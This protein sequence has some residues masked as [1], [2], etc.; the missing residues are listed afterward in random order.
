MHRLSFAVIAATS[1]VALSQ[2]ASAA[3]LPRKAPVAPV[4]PVVMAPNWT[5]FYGGANIGWI[6]DNYD[7]AYTNPAPVTCCTPFSMSTDSVTLGLHGGGQVQFNQFVLGVEA[8]ILS[9]ANHFA[10]QSVCIRTVPSLI[11]QTERGQITTVGGR[12]GWA[13]GDWLFFGGGGWARGN[14]HSQVASPSGVVDVTND[15]PH[16]G[17]Y[18][19]GG[20]EYMLMKG[21]VVD[22]IVGLEYQHIDLGTE[23]QAASSDGFSPAPPGVNGRNIGA[24]EDLVRAR[25]SVKLNPFAH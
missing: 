13:W 2:I 3:D 1:V 12:L 14:V 5:G 9:G 11:C 16:T 19:G 17:W 24:T 6:H 7:W 21:Q 18:A 15:P 23:F 4:A 25:V 22:L 10:S 20:V 8:A